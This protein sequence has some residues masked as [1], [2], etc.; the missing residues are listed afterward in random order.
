MDSPEMLECGVRYGE[1][2]ASAHLE[3]VQPRK[4]TKV[5]SVMGDSLPQ[6]VMLTF[7]TPS[8]YIRSLALMFFRHLMHAAIAFGKERHHN[9][10]LPRISVSIWSQG[11]STT[12]LS[13][14]RL[15]KRSFL[16]S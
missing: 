15:I 12:A 9:F 5:A 6:A 1:L 7:W 10:R 3:G 2:I 4:C 16:A 13:M 11:C 8:R 14:L